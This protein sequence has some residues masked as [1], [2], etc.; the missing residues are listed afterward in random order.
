MPG[1]AFIGAKEGE[2]PKVMR[3]TAERPG[4]V[5]AWDLKTLTKKWEADRELEVRWGGPLV[6]AVLREL[7][8]A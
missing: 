3:R 1:E 5:C 4:R 8:A 6:T 2:F 7:L